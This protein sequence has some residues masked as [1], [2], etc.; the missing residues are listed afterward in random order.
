MSWNM[1]ISIFAKKAARHG[2]CYQKR[3]HI[4]AS[5]YVAKQH[6]KILPL[7]PCT[8]PPLQLLF[9]LVEGNSRGRPHSTLLFS[10]AFGNA[11]SALTERVGQGG[12]THRVLVHM[13]AASIKELLWLA[14][15][16]PI[17]HELKK[18]LNNRKAYSVL[19]RT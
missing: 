8:G 14:P 9:P 16:R 18:N 7:W 1:V 17:L 13:A 11:G 12:V 5:I 3:E 4:L 19:N 2:C 6:C 10:L 15:G